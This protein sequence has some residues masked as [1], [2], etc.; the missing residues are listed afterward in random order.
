[1]GVAPIVVVANPAAGHGK[2]GKVV[3]KVDHLLDA[4]RH[5]ARDRLVDVRAGSTGSASARAATD[6]A[7]TVGCIG[8]DGTVGL[9]ANGLIGTDTTLAVFPSGT[10]D[11]FAH[12]IGLRNLATT[13]HALAAGNDGPDRHGE[14]T[15]SG[16]PPGGT[17]R[18]RAAGSTPR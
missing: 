3:G 2:A 8:G 5:R 7:P 15:T 4:G 16:A 11:D 12:A 6:G 9:A 18:S 17:W 13:V 14:V 1:M 10:A